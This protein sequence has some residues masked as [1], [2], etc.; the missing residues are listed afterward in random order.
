MVLVDNARPERLGELVRG[1]LPVCPE[2]EVHCDA[3]RLLAAP[4]GGTVVLEVDAKQAE[5]L[6]VERPVVAH[7]ELRLFLFS[8]STTSAALSRRA[9][10]LF[11]WISHRVECPAG[12]WMPHVHAIRRALCARAPGITWTGGDLDGALRAALPGRA[13]SNIS[14]TRPYS[15]LV[16]GASPRGSSWVAFTDVDT[17][18]RRRRIAWAIA[19]SG[20]RSK[21]ALV[22]P[23]GSLPGFLA[24]PSRPASLR[25]AMKRLEAAGA[26]RAGQL[27]A[28]LD[29]EETSIKLATKLLRGGVAEGEIRAAAAGA[30][31]P[32]DAID[33]LARELGFAQRRPEASARS[34][35]KE[36]SIRRAL[37]EPA[38]LLRE[39]IDDALLAGDPQVAERWAGR[40]LLTD[41]ESAEAM[42]LL[43]LALYKQGKLREPVEPLKAAVAALRQDPAS[44]PRS[45]AR[46][47]DAMGQVLHDQ[48]EYAEALTC[49]QDA[50]TLLRR[51]RDG[52]YHLAISCV[53]H[54]GS[55]LTD[56]GRSADALRLLKDHFG[57]APEDPREP[58]ARIARLE[59]A[60]A[61]EQTLIERARNDEA[62][63]LLD[64]TVAHYDLTLGSELLRHA[65][66]A[67][68]A[69]HALTIFKR[70][71]EAEFLLR[72]A[73]EMQDEAGLER[74]G[75]LLCEL[76]FSLLK[77]GKYAEAKS[78]LLAAVAHADSAGSLKWQ[79]DAL[80]L[81]GFLLGLQGHQAEEER[82]IREVLRIHREIGSFTCSSYA[83]TLHELA[84]IATR[85]HRYE[86]AETSLREALSIEEQTLDS[87]PRAISETLTTL[88]GVLALQ[89]RFEEAERTCRR[90]LVRA[91]A[92]K[93][94]IQIAKA[95]SCLA[96]IEK[97]MNRQQ[98]ADTAKRAIDA[99][100]KAY[101]A[102]H[103]ATVRAK[104]ELSP[105]I[106]GISGKNVR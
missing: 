16:E 7:R 22:L 4:K 33:R 63:S 51:N 61:L 70:P 74:P 80:H 14:T 54:M 34:R 26:R 24:A 65:H 6:N 2:L 28:A 20:R 44:D 69:G 88:S 35:A 50:I 67:R 103:P 37:R 36:P 68:S 93:S 102:N 9:V 64:E 76:G 31:W 21:T 96:H 83:I 86:E 75:P 85:E 56:Q 45:Q 58:H 11:H 17:A 106:D 10:D 3:R 60:L 87:P 15:E 12:A 78:L 39:W 105:I 95:L 82:H 27:A 57:R 71:Q 104:R 23:N 62:K 29:L 53:A 40:W 84:Q 94:R 79:A 52:G 43:G 101:G 32:G 66:I 30:P 97:S 5:W 46:A 72:K 90:S 98:A 38:V 13:L 92:A 73:L 49:F 41:A 1:L 89:N 47:L 100:A 81:L 19:E 25:D 91:R 18:F 55:L 42:T 77:Q 48:G 8:D 59:L 99:Y